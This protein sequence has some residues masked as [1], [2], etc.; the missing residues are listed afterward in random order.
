MQTTG[1]THDPFSADGK[2]RPLHWVLLA[3]AFAALSLAVM[4]QRWGGTVEDSLAYFN[5]ARFLRGE[6]P[7]SALRAPFPYRLAMPGL[8]A[9]WPGDLR[10]GFATLNWLATAASATVLAC[11]VHAAG[12]DRRRVVAAGLLAIVSVPTFWYAPYLLTDPG[13]IL[14]RS[15][16]ALGVVLSQP[17]LALAGGLFATTVREENIL[18]LAWLLAFGRVGIVRG[19]V[20]LALAAAWLVVVRWY[21]FPGLPSYVWAPNIGTVVTALRD[22]RSLLSLLGA[23]ILVI[24]LACLGWKHV[25]ER[26]KPLKGI[27]LMMALPP[28]YAALSVRIEGRAIWSLY[29]FL[30]PIAV[31]ARVRP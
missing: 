19:G 3:L 28:L 11:L 16:F 25:P 21:V 8:A 2:W 29:P 12:G 4:W 9:L 5:T 10:N 6:V 24:P 15:V 14:G 22:V 18:L 17:W 26:I 13:A 23:G 27:L 31:F 7:F 30:I 1:S 20:V